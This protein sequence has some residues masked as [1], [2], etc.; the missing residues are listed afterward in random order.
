M[1]LQQHCRVDAQTLCSYIFAVE[2]KRG[3]HMIKNFQ[4]DLRISLR[5]TVDGSEIQLISLRLVVGS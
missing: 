5:H 4:K 3:V 1:F 2:I